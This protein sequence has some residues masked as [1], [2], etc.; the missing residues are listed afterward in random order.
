MS[1]SASCDGWASAIPRG[2]DADLRSAVVST[3]RRRRGAEMA[4]RKRRS[5]NPDGR[6]SQGLSETRVLVPMPEQ[7]ADD[8]ASAAEAEGVSRAEWI[9]RAMAVRLRI[10]PR[11]PFEPIIPSQLA[12]FGPPRD[13]DQLTYSAGTAW[14]ATRDPQ[15]PAVGDAGRPAADAAR[16]GRTVARR[17]R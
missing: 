11:P 9:R 12:N 1:S 14:P 16:L 13:P 6:P 7:L 4:K 15:R 17:T 3:L 8:A 2:S 10:P 5:N